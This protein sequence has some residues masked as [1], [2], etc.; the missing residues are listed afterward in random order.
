MSF[1]ASIN[2]TYFIAENFKG[3]KLFVNLD[4]ENLYRLLA[5]SANGCHAPAKNFY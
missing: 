1:L 4:R 2:S 3:R 5:Y